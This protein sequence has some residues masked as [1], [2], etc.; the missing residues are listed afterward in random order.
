MKTIS[1]SWS[2][3]TTRVD[4]FPLAADE[5]AHTRVE[6][7]ADGVN[8]VE[9]GTVPAPG[10]EFSQPEVEPGSYLVRLT[11]VDKQT[12][13]KASPGVTASAEVPSDAAPSDV[14][15]IVV[16]VA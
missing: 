2:L 14:A 6:L 7:S 1:V 12:P 8:F 10:H 13:P 16:T 3:P 9:L 4:G 11:V 15:D 5:I